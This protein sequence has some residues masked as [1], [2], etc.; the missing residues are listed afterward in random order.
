MKPENTNT[1]NHNLLE[2]EI[3][4]EIIDLGGK[5][6][7]HIQAGRPDASEIVAF[8]KSELLASGEKVHLVVSLGDLKVEANPVQL[9]FLR[10]PEVNKK[11]A[12]MTVVKNGHRISGFAKSYLIPVFSKIIGSRIA[13]Y[14]SF[15]EAIEHVKS[16]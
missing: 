9:L 14:P 11:V 13:I 5:K 6:V 16:L 4:S 15:D 2:R 7:L 1:T 10:E 3:T 8:T 12:S